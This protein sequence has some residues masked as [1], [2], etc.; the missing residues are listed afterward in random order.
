[1][2][3]AE[4]GRR[5]LHMF[6]HM[7]TRFDVI[8]GALYY[9]LVV[10]AIPRCGRLAAVLDAP[11]LGAAL[12]SLAGAARDAVADIILESYVSLAAVV[13]MFALAL[14]FASTGGVG[15]KGGARGGGPAC[16]GAGGL[17]EWPV[18]AA[19][20]GGVRGADD[21]VSPGFA[22]TGWPSGS[23]ARMQVPS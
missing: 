7:N 17:D 15:A 10:S 3:S 16:V 21:R 14:G 2:Q 6:R 20:T 18:E 5:N 4:L 8:G 11:S 13:A 12:L 1:M 19:C 23:L 9:M 22:R